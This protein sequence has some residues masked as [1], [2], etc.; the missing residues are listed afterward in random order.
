MQKNELKKML[1][2]EFGKELIDLARQVLQRYLTSGKRESV[3][4]ELLKKYPV[5]SEPRGVFV[6]L[7]K[8]KITQ[9]KD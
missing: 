9:V 3:S 6:T 1:S 5:L 2:E 4:D 7:R 8:E